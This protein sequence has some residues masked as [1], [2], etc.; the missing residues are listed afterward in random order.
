M[1]IKQQKI[2]KLGNDPGAP[3]NPKIKK[4]II[5]NLLNSSKNQLI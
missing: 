2:N 1:G 3:E 5:I 4:K